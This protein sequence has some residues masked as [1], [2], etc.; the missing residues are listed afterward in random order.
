MRGAHGAPV[1][2]RAAAAL[3]LDDREVATAGLRGQ[4]HVMAVAAGAMPDWSTMTVEGPMAGPG[5]LDAGWCEWAAT[6]TVSGATHD[7]SDRVIDALAPG[8]RYRTQRLVGDTEP[9]AGR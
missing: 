5:M 9:L 3:P 7:L 1:M 2:Y 4:L 6:V 8:E